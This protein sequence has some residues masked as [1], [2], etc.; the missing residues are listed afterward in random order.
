M[1]NNSDIISL[2]SS[3]DAQNSSRL[4]TRYLSEDVEYLMLANHPDSPLLRQLRGK[5]AVAEYLS[6]LPRLYEISSRTVDRV[7]QDGPHT[8]VLGRDLATIYP[9]KRRIN[10]N[11]T[12]ILMI[13]SNIILRIQ[14]IFQ[15]MIDAA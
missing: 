4:L 3:N 13:Q 7:L 9:Q 5:E 11:W 8:V 2:L 1:Q 15:N 12:A 6:I 10:A 14:Y